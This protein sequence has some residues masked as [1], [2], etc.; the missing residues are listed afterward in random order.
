MQYLHLFPVNTTVVIPDNFLPFGLMY[1]DSV[2]PPIDDGSSQEV[3]L[4]T[5][6]I[7]FGSRNS[8]LYVSLYSV[9]IGYSWST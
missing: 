4:G 6:V 1:G 2:I 3:L 8:R 7:I 9:K 5:D